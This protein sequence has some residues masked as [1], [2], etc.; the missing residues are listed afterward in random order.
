MPPRALIPRCERCDADPATRCRRCG[1][2]TCDEHAPVGG[3]RCAACEAEWQDGARSRRA[4]KQMF[5]PAAFVLGGGAV[6]GAL[7]PLVA[8]LPPLT[9]AVVVAAL[10]TAI[11][12]LAAAGTHN[13]VDAAARAQFLRDHSR[14]LPEARARIVH[15]PHH[16]ALLPPHR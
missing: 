7:L 14:A 13:L 3:K 11:G 5:A 1:A 12:I 15:H 10:S 16:R 9:G 4:V 8:I 6:F 2:P